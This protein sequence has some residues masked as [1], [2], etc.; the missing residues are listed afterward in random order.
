[1][2]TSPKPL[3]ETLRTW[4]VAPLADAGFRPAVWSRI[5]AARR[6]VHENWFGYLR[7]HA[8]AWSFVLVATAAGAGLLGSHAGERRA[9]ADHA[10]ILDTYL[11]QIDAR[12]MHR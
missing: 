9:V 12:A 4:Q 5:E 1:M 7:R 8:I 3:R 2:N 10:S 11:A 6:A